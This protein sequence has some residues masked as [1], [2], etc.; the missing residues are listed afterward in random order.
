MHWVRDG[1]CHL[2]SGFLGPLAKPSKF[3]LGPFDCTKVIAQEAVRP[4]EIIFFKWEMCSFEVDFLTSATKKTSGSRSEE[5]ERIT[6]EDAIFNW[7]VSSRDWVISRVEVLFC[8]P[9]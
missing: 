6:L 2:V 4:D 7:D 3:L 5:R 9:E 1:V 8:L